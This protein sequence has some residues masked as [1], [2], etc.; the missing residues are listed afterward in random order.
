MKKFYNAPFVKVEIFATADVITV[1]G[2]TL[3][4]N[5]GTVGTDEITKVDANT[6][7]FN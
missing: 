4:N 5:K 1:S 3:I 6:L 7:T 2:L